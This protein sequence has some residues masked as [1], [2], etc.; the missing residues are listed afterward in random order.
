[1]LLAIAVPI[2]ITASLS[3]F[4]LAPDRVLYQT[5]PLSGL[6]HYAWNDI[7]SVTPTCSPDK[8]TGWDT[9]YVIT[10]HDGSAFDILVWPR[11][12]ARVYP[13]IVQA[14]HGLG[15]SF[16]ASR[17]QD[18]CNVPYVEILRERP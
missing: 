4:C 12:T 6:R 10:M 13:K 11:P 9:T 8:R 5:S 15:F 2:S 1:V 18:R 7:A 17:V 16:D 14:L 3:Q